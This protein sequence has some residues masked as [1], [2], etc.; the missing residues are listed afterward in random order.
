M[1][2]LNNLG[3]KAETLKCLVVALFSPQIKTVFRP[4]GLI[5]FLLHSGCP[6]LANKN[7]VLQQKRLM[8]LEFFCNATLSGMANEVLYEA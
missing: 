3:A 8:Y 2:S 1:A 7:W 6:V 4:T 5:L